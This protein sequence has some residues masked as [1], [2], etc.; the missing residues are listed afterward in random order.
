MAFS[1]DEYIEVIV[2]QIRC[3]F[4]QLEKTIK[5]CLKLQEA[6]EEYQKSKTEKAKKE[7]SLYRQSIG[8]IACDGYRS[9]EPLT[10]GLFFWEG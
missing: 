9:I 4:Q 2:D 10:V 8:D 7:I 5:I 6:I 1:A 3:N